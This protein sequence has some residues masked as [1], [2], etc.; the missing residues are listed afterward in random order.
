MTTNPLDAVRPPEP[1]R[2]ARRRG[3]RRRRGRGGEEP[4]VPDAEFASYYGRPVVRPAP[5]EADIPAYLFLGGLAA[6][7][8]L[9]GAGA[10]ATGRPTLR[11]NGRY[12]AMAAVAAGGAALVHDLGRPERFVNML[13]TVKLTSPMSVGTWILS[14]FSAATGAATAVEVSRRLL[15]EGRLTRAVAPF[16]GP[17]SAASAL[18]APPLAAYTSVLLSDTATP[19]WNASWREMP[20]LFVG[21]AQAAAGGLA[22]V[23]TPVA[24]AGPARAM[25]GGGAALD[26][27]ATEILRRRLRREG[28]G[29]PMER[30]RAGA[31]IRASTALTVAGGLGTVLI[32]RHRLGAAL[33]GAAL[34][35]GS[36]LTRFGIFEAGI[37]SARDPKYTVE[38][39][40]RRRDEAAGDRAGGQLG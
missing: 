15:G 14:G 31:M 11:R 32:G 1:D 37:E 13:R 23:T 3:R 12:A 6:G 19:T 25:A 28:V 2:A 40:R 18:L 4:V 5:W 26:I 24:E 38:P 27:A 10:A 16:E 22:M 34:V 7:S 20:F 8:G 17:A 36:V 21:S 35:A 30:G 39:Q 33:S 29:E 9:L